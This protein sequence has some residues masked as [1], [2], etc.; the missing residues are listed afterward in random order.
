[1][2]G[3]PRV[4]V[5]VPTH[6]RVDSLLRTVAALERQ[7]FSLDEME[8]VVVADGC[9]DDTI[10]V[11]EGRA[12]PLAQTVVELEGL[13]AGAAR[14][15]GA[16]AARGALLLFLDDDIEPAPELVAAHVRA[17]AAWPGRVVMGPYPPSLRGRSAFFRMQ[18]RSWWHSH[19]QELA[20]PG[21]RFTYL[22]LVSGN[23]SIDSELFRELGGFD[24]AIP[25][26]GGEDYEFGARAI[27]AG[28]EIA[29]EADARALHHEHETMTL[30][31]AF[32]R[33]RQEGRANVVIGRRHPELRRELFWDM[34]ESQEVS[35]R[36]LRQI[37]FRR[38]VL[39]RVLAGAARASLA[40]FE[41]LKMRHRWRKTFGALV[42]Y[43][44]LRGVADELGSEDAL[45]AY[46][47]RSPAE[48]QTA[49]AADLV[50]DLALGL[51]EAERQLDRCRPGAVRLVYGTYEM[52]KVEP[53]PAAEP[54]R[55][56]HLRPMLAERFAWEIL[57]ALTHRA[58]TL[59]ERE[60]RSGAVT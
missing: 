60:P 55:G 57:R 25:G 6:N 18:A 2:S 11:L 38:R 41:V 3:R 49:G 1:M 52:G 24:E 9:R 21:H 12:T 34:L 8:L 56:A 35:H 36:F 39:G 17:H 54:L 40:P 58:T 43:W 5:I 27:K 50:L 23:L 51:E 48:P 7:Q 14:N 53:I 28:I 4:S 31:G 44:R 37:V 13:G 32:R 33:A 30:D 26:A 42:A 46:I 19:F 15:A 16:S 47:E 22:D 45:A 29:F 59:S 10:R 20:R